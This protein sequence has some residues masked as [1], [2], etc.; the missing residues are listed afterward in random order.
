MTSVEI[1]FKNE[2]ILYKRGTGKA[3][4]DLRTTRGFLYH[5][6]GNSE[7]GIADL[8]EALHINNN[9]SFAYRNLG[10]IYYDLGN[11]NKACEYLQKARTLGYKKIYDTYDLQEYLEFSCEQ[12]IAIEN[13]SEI[14]IEPV[15]IS[16]LSDKPFI[17]PNPTKGEVK[18]KNL[19]FKDYDYLVYDYSGRLVMQG[20]SKNNPIN[21]S[22]LP[23]GVYILK[24]F[25][26]DLSETFRVVKE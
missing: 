23:S 8:E 22:Q 19:S 14:K 3:E 4:R 25:K 5:K 2:A 9:N 20:A 7:K 12:V 26:N 6:L 13:K 21:V 11:Y 17:Y 18:I 16:K 10:I 24:V 15:K 1:A